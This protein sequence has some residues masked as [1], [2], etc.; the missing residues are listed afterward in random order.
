M[1]TPITVGPKSAVSQVHHSK[2]EMD[3]HWEKEMEREMLRE[4]VLNLGIKTSCKKA[5]HSVI[6]DSG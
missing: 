4:K 2:E 6:D 1:I 3:K 5:S